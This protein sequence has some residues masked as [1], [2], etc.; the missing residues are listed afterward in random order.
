MIS[1]WQQ[2]TR[3]QRKILCVL[4][5]TCKLLITILKRT[6][7]RWKFAERILDLSFQMDLVFR[8]RKIIIIYTNMRSYNY[9]VLMTVAE[10]NSGWK[11]PACL[12]TL[13]KDSLLLMEEVL[14]KKSNLALLFGNLHFPVPPADYPHKKSMLRP[15]KIKIMMMKKNFRPRALNWNGSLELG[16]YSV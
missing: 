16:F 5:H 10:V 6:R 8:Y 11:F 3:M 14:L 9:T 1:D 12:S 7:A 13:L 2:L 15:A 4:L